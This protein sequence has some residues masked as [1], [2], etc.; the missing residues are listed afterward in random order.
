MTHRW[1]FALVWLTGGVAPAAMA[2][3]PAP[4]VVPE[5]R[6]PGDNVAFWEEVR[7]AGWVGF[8]ETWDFDTCNQGADVFAAG[9]NRRWKKMRPV[10]LAGGQPFGLT[11]EDVAFYTTIVPY[12]AFGSLLGVFLLAWGF[13]LI[14]RRRF[15]APPLIPCPTCGAKL[16]VSEEEG[17]MF[18]P[19]CGTAVVG[20]GE[21][22]A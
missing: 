10:R 20:P 14:M 15:V 13:A 17:G 16:P 21:A 4:T 5:F 3:A 19:G 11:E 6:C 7:E 8:G 12:L 22:P 1:L 18:C 9:A 2:Q